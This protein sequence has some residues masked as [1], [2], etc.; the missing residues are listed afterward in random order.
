MDTKTKL[1][2]E[3]QRNGS[4]VEPMDE[5]MDTSQV[6]GLKYS[7][8][9]FERFGDDFC[10]HLLSFLTLKDKI[11]LEMVSKQWKRTIYNKQ[12]DL[13]VFNVFPIEPIQHLINSYVNDL[14]VP[15]VVKNFVSGFAN[16]MN[17]KTIDSHR[18]KSLLSKCKFIKNI[19]LTRVYVDSDLLELIGSYCPNLE[20]IQLDMIGLEEKDIDRFGLKYGK[21]LKKIKFNN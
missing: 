20:R 13:R 6:F 11:V 18:L 5:V 16:N 9:S 3:C 4:D 15:I 17:M 12:T 19:E 14:L 7:R 21:Q 10:E 1:V 8:N 2:K